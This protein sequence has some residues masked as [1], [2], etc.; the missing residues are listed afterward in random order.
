MKIAGSFEDRL[1]IDLVTV[2]IPSSLQPEWTTT[3]LTPGTRCCV[4]LARF[5][6]IRFVSRVCHSNR[7]SAL[8]PALDLKTGN[9]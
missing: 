2:S 6:E 5:P 9:S 7:A 4:D 1:A 8:R 3:G